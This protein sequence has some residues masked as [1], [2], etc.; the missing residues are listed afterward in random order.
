[1]SFISD[2]RKT[3]ENSFLCTVRDKLFQG[4]FNL[5]CRDESFGQSIVMH[6]VPWGF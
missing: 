3:N 6:L 4:L 2:P 5:F 1:M